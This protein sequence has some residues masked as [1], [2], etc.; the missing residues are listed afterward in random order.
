[1]GSEFE[2]RKGQTFSILYDVHTGSG[3]HR[4]SYPMGKMGPFPGCKAA[5]A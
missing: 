4:D 3:A 1:M 5:R 2:S